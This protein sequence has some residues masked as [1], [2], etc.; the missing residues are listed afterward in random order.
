[1]SK[2][3]IE[4]KQGMNVDELL[5][6]VDAGHMVELQRGAK[7]LAHLAPTQQKRN[8]LL[9]THLTLAKTEEPLP[10]GFWL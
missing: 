7:T 3:T 10:E 8:E 5:P 2:K 1:M 9:Y 6:L 4:W